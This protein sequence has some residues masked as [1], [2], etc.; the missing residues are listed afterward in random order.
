[1]IAL[2]KEKW[3]KVAVVIVNWNGGRFLERC[4][5][6][7][8]TQTFAPQEIILVDNASTDSSIEIARRFPDVCLLAQQDNLGFAKANN[9]AVSRTSADVEWIALLNPDAF[10]GPRW[11]EALISAVQAHPD[12]DIFGSRLLSATAPATLD[13]TG[14]VYHV[15]GLV[16]REDHGRTDD[17]SVHESRE[18]FSPCAAAALY[19]KRA[20]V[21]AGGFDEE[22]FCYVE[23]V[24]LGFRLRLFGHRCLY[25]PKAEVFHMGSA[26]TGRH[27][28]FAVYYGHR[29]LVWT[30]VKNMPGLLFWL[31]LPAHALLNVVSVI[32]FLVMGKGRLILKTKA[33]AFRGLP[34]MWKKRRGIHRLRQASVGDIWK[35]L[36]KSLVPRL[37]KT[38]W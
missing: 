29:N 37:Y 9:L 28:D 26:T 19:S 31:F 18:I 32:W 38:W 27:S 6:M 20:F 2:T 24:D 13:G 33:D 14:D 35:N 4:L 8:E 23:D 1:M 21:D 25:V 16:W 22:Y 12:F 11:L 3:P 15:S 10:P 34:R 5:S 7:L 17:I 36:D 30:Y